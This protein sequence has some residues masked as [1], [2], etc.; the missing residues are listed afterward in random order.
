MPNL[1]KKPTDEVILRNSVS[2]RRSRGAINGALGRDKGFEGRCLPGNAIKGRQRA[3]MGAFQAHCSNGT[4]IGIRVEKGE[5]WAFLGE[6]GEIWGCK[7]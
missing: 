2:R 7:G 4:Q 1:P 6:M 3:F 5:K